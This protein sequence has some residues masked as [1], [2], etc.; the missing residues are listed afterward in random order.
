MLDRE[1]LRAEFREFINEATYNY[2]IE[3]KG[4]PYIDLSKDKLLTKKKSFLQQLDD[5]KNK[6]SKGGDKKILS[7]EI[8]EY[9]LK[10]KQV[11]Y[12]LKK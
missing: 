2:D 6:L 9:K 8:A 1:K 10:I 3:G 5:L 12:L 11:E 7:T 4:N